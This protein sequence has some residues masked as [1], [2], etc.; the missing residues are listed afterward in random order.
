MLVGMYIPFQS[1]IIP[2]FQV[3]RLLNL[4]GRLTGVVVVHV[5]YGVPI[6]T[7]IFRDYY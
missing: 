5:I 2:L 7:L 6:T 3:P 1:V 4:Q